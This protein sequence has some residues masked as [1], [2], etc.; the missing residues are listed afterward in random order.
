MLSTTR[1]PT[2]PFRWLNV[3][4]LMSLLAV[5]GTAQCLAQQAPTPA[6]SPATP[7]H[8][9]PAVDRAA[10]PSAAGFIASLSLVGSGAIELTSCTDNSQ[11]TPPQLCCRA[12]GFVG[13]TAMACLNPFHGRCPPIP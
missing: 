3:L 7:S 11:C 5:L 1:R 12:C 13:C 6:M 2:R 10:G 8:A 4:L 9:A